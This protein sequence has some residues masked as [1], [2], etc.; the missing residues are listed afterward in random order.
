MLVAP[1][2]ATAAPNAKAQAARYCAMYRGGGE[3]CG[4]SSMEQ[5]RQSLAG[6]GGMC[7]VVQSAPQP[8]KLAPVTPLTPRDAED[9]E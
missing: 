4:F 9:T 5:C 1:P 2:V 8:K 7:V 6:S 3:N